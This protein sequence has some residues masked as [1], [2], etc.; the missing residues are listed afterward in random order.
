MA[1]ARL[2]CLGRQLVIVWNAAALG[3]ACMAGRQS[4]QPCRD[5]IQCAGRQLLAPSRYRTGL[6]PVL[7]LVRRG[8]LACVG[9]ALAFAD[10]GAGLPYECLERCA[11][12][13]YTG[14]SAGRSSLAGATA[15]WGDHSGRR[16]WSGTWFACAAGSVSAGTSVGHGMELALAAA[17]RPALSLGKD[18]ARR[19]VEG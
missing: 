7:T 1:C 8:R 12:F 19:Y 2:V 17:D 9:L 13:S 11:T 5:V 4:G 15:R 6:S 18:T 3:L 10:R 16:L 14:V